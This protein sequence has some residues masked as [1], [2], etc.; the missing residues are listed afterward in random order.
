VNTGIKFILKSGVPVVVP[1]VQA[2]A[3]KIVMDWHTGAYLGKSH[4]RYGGQVP[5]GAGGGAWSVQ[6]AEI[7]AVHTITFEPAAIQ[8]PTGLP[9]PLQQTSGPLPPGVP[10]VSGDRQGNRL[11]TPFR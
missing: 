5:A 1:M 10:L 11:G 6:I 7:A 2:E 8:L 9:L 4:I 3:E